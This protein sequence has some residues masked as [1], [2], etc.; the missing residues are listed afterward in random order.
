MLYLEHSA[1]QQEA[2]FRAAAD[3]GVR[4]LRMDFAV[5]NVFAWDR[6]DFS[7]VERVDE[8]A[9]RY[10]VVSWASSPTRPGTSPSAR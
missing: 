6:T 2:L 3:A 5:G 10:R 1:V 4:Y 8:L 7:A 9:A